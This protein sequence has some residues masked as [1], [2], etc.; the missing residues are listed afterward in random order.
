MKH[1]RNIAMIV[2]M[3]ITWVAI[4]SVAQESLGRIMHLNSNDGLSNDYVKSM[5][6]A[7]NGS[8]WI[9]TEA[10]LNRFDGHTFQIYTKDNSG[11]SSN[12]LNYVLYDPEPNTVWIA[13]QRDGLCYYH[14]PTDSIYHLSTADGLVTNDITHLSAASDGGIWVTHYYLG[15]QHLSLRPEE[16]KERYT[17]NNVTGDPMPHTNWTAVDDKKGHLYVGHAQEGGMS[18]IDIA[19][20]ECRNFR[21]MPSDKN[22]LPGNEVFAIC[23]DRNGIVWAGT[24]KGAASYNPATGVFTRIQHRPDDKESLLPGMIMD[25]HQMDNGDI[26]F[27]SSQGG[28]SILS[29]QTHTFVNPEEFKFKNIVSSETDQTINGASIRSILQDSYGNVW[30]GSYRNGID[31][32]SSAPRMFNRVE[33]RSN[34]HNGHRYRTVWCVTTGSEGDLWM[35]GEGEIAHRLADGKIDIIPLPTIKLHP[36]SYVSSLLMDKSHRLWIGTDEAGAFI[37]NPTTQN[38]LQLAG[39]PRTIRVFAEEKDGTVLIGTTDGL[40]ASTDGLNASLC[41]AITDQLEDKAVHGIIRD[42]AGKLWVGTFGKGLWVFDRS[43]SLIVKLRV[44]EGFPS[45]AVNSMSQDSKGRIWVATRNGVVMFEDT[46]RPDDYKVIDITDGDYTPQARAIEEDNEGNI[47]ISTDKSIVRLNEA[48][49]PTTTYTHYGDIRLN[50]FLDHSSATDSTG[51]VYFGSLNGLFEF[52]PAMLGNPR[53]PPTPIIPHF[54]LLEN[55]GPVIDSESELRIKAGNVT[56]PHDQNSF[57]IEISTPDYSFNGEVEYSYFME[58]IDNAWHNVNDQRAVFRNLPPG[59]YSFKV[60]SRM[61]GHEWTDNQTSLGITITPPV[62]QTWWARTIYAILILALIIFLIHSY[63]RRMK[64]KQTLE[65]ERQNSQNKQL[66]NEERL[67]FYTNITHEL[68]TPLTLILGPLEDLLSDKHLSSKHTAKIQVIHDSSM[69][70]LNLI[71]G[72]LEFR[73]T[74]TQ[75]RKLSVKKANLSNLVR[76]IGLRYKELNRNPRVEYVINL[77][78]DETMIYFDADMITT[79]LDNLLSNATKYT[80]EGT[81]TLSMSTSEENG[82]KYTD[83]TVADTG[84]GISHEELSH[85]FERYYQGKSPYQ[86]SGSGIGLALVKSLAELHNATLSVESE[87]EKGTKFTLRLLSDSTYPDA[88]HG[89]LTKLQPESWKETEAESQQDDRP[90]LLVVEDDT[91]IQQYIANSLSDEFTVSCASNGQEGLAITQEKIPDIVV[92]DIMM[93]IMDGISLC[94]AIRAEISTSHVPVV[95]LTARDSTTDKEEGYSAGADSYLTKPFSAKL[96]RSRLHNLLDNRR[97]MAKSIM[98]SSRQPADPVVEITETAI[99]PKMNP[100]DAKFIEKIASI[101]EQN[102][103]MEKLDIAFIAGEMAMSHSTLYRK[104]K[105]VAGMSVNEFIRKVK[106]RKASE[107]LQAGNHTVS[108]ISYMTGFSSVAYFRQCF[109]AEFGVSPSEYSKSNSSSPATDNE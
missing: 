32:I 64:L 107:A 35:G 81:I 47:W 4:Q 5:A 2:F 11:L 7:P 91:D 1:S 77:D 38:A 63:N 40:Y 62:W 14:Y 52:N 71:N 42:K 23:I 43:D 33:Y 19:T 41:Q 101:V 9:A 69:R 26:W 78:S 76:E 94:R 27:A 34:P 106:L 57:A 55:N 84:H 108:E 98:A 103:E 67:R 16:K 88:L 74:E 24:D 20:K 25:I 66:L 105:A 85:I 48:L 37:Y 89:G 10:G 61:L 82:V 60:R 97:R 73:K 51:H 109:K 53:Q 72:I 68:R 13:T 3:A 70:L 17:Y 58:G 96:L 79:I 36:Y 102:L 80:S 93:P 59:K 12:E 104:V 50:S 6:Q 99:Q 49:V 100:L 87:V 30:L 46:D 56:L 44:E 86:A 22:S 21:S 31:F 54:Y 29:M 15:I 45:N 75:N 83:L 28:V 65:I 18:I 92:S 90:I 95:L 8:I 39:M